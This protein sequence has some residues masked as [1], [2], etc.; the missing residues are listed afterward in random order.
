MKHIK[1]A[2]F[3]Y[4][5]MNIRANKSGLYDNMLTE[6][7]KEIVNQRILDAIWYPYE[8]FKMIFS[9][10]AKVEAKGDLNNIIKW[11]YKHAQKT[12]DRMY[13]DRM[14]KRSLK[15]AISTYDHLFKLWFDFG[16]QESNIISDN[17]I[18]ISFMDFDD[19]FDLFY[20]VA[21][22]WIQSF[23]EAYLGTK[24]KTKF[25]QKSWE[26]ADKTTINVTWNS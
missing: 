12:I 21:S 25:L 24:I 2:L 15:L 10:V 4:F 17:E 19:D 8:Q 14:K 18:N 20:Y 6:E 5:I 26:G 11:G 9:R 3:K 13:K 16:K 22:G 23:F 7:E 1:G